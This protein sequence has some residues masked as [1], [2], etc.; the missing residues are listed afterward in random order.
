MPSSL[1]VTGPLIS[2][3]IPIAGASVKVTGVGVAKL[4]SPL[5]P[6]A[7]VP[8]SE[9]SLITAPLGLVPLTFA[10]LLY[11]PKL[12]PG[13]MVTVRSSVAEDEATAP[14]VSV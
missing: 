14:E 7:S 1:L 4:P 5:S 8:S 13:V 12:A 9:S 2:F 10:V 3:A 11:G 6:L